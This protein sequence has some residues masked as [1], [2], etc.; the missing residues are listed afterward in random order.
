MYWSQWEIL[1]NMLTC[2][3]HRE[4]YL[5]NMLTCTDHSERYLYNML[6]CTDHSE[7]YVYYNVNM[8]W[9]QREILV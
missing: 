3:D 2:T 5:Y 4:R 7:R 1:Y 8:Y 9:S 6:T